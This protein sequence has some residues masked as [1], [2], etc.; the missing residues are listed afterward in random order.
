MYAFINLFIHTV[1]FPDSSEVQANLALLGVCAGHFARLELVGVAS[2]LS[3]PFVTELAVLARRHVR[4]VRND[5]AK[6]RDRLK[7]GLQE[8]LDRSPNQ[9]PAEKPNMGYTQPMDHQLYSD[10]SVSCH[11]FLDQHEVRKILVC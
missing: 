6:R 7:T 1:K 4:S 10:F 5:P 2:E 3:F 11:S 9:P 8:E